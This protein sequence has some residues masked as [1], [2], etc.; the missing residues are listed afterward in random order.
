MPRQAYCAAPRITELGAAAARPPAAPRRRPS[1]RAVVDHEELAATDWL[2]KVNKLRVARTAPG[3]AVPN[4]PGDK[5]GPHQP[6]QVNKGHASGAPVR[7]TST[8]LTPR[9]RG[10]VLAKNSVASKQPRLP[11]DAL[12]LIVLP[13]GGLL[14]SKISTYQLLEAVCNAARFTRDAVRHEDLIQANLIQNTFAYC[15]PDL[16]RAERVLQVKEITIDNK[17]YEVSVYC[18]PDDSSGRGVIRGVDVRLDRDTIQAELQDNRNP[19]IVDFRR[20]G[21]TTAVLITFAQP[22]VPAWIYF[23][24]SRHRCNLFKKKY[25]VCYRCGE[26]G[27]RA[28]VCASPTK[29][30]RGCELPNPP[31]DH[32]CIPTCRLCGKEHL[33]GDSRCKEIFRIPYTVK[34]R[35]WEK[36]RQ[37]EAHRIKTQEPGKQQTLQHTSR[38]DQQ[39]SG[40]RQRQRQDRSSSFPPLESTTPKGRFQTSSQKRKEPP[41]LTQQPGA[42]SPLQHPP[43]PPSSSPDPQGHQQPVTTQEGTPSTSD[44]HKAIVELTAV[45]QQL[46][47]RV[48]AL[49]HRATSHT[50]S[51]PAAQSPPTVEPMEIALSSGHEHKRKAPADSDPKAEDWQTRLDRLEKKYELTHTHIRALEAHI[52]RSLHAIGSQVAQQMENLSK[53]HRSP[54]KTPA[55][56]EPAAANFPSLI[57]AF[58]SANTTV[59]QWNCRG[60]AR[61]RPVLQQFLTAS[62]RPELIALQEGGKNTQLAGFTTYFSERVKPQVATLVKRNLTVIDWDLLRAH[63]K[64]QDAPPTITNINAWTTEIVKQVADATQT[65][66]VED[67]VPYCDRYY[68]HLWKR[69]K[70]LEALL[71]TRKWDRD[72]RRRLARAH[73]NIENYAIELT[74]QSW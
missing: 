71:S 51:P 61:K 6:P 8:E 38:W 22:Q 3:S 47:V 49:E 21:N 60:F 5:A 35:Q 62:D 30:C 25:E 74:R 34:R 14:L 37:A 20:L 43:A 29:K 18:A 50:L 39:R 73:T 27:H 26:L 45:I 32:T 42:S 2:T 56:A 68:A 13:H 59:W 19:P 36:H 48:E 23:C 69:K 64:E 4:S 7:K 65:V 63:R 9:Q 58:S 66:D 46:I 28:D 40:S 44:T 12:K 16:E 15:T 24:N 72:I 41:A 52:E 67:T 1:L 33:M 57:M 70:S 17:D 53:I 31:T 55:I 10:R 11:S 54:G